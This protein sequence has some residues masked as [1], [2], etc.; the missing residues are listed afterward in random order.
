MNRWGPGPPKCWFH[1]YGLG[2]KH[3]DSFQLDLVVVTLSNTFK[4]DQG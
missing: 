2:L 4:D 3:I 1:G